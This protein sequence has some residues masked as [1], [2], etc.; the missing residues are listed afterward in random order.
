[1]KKIEWPGIATAVGII[2]ILALIVLGARDDF[3]LKEWQTVI[4]SVIALT[5]G[6]LAYV[7]A[8][9][10]VRAEN[11]SERRELDRKKIGAYYRLGFAITQ[12]LVDSQKVLDRTEYKPFA[13]P[14]TFSAAD[15]Q[16]SKPPEIDELWADIEIFPKKAIADIHCI[17]VMF[18]D[19]DEALKSGPENYQ[20]T[21]LG[22]RNDK[23][24]GKY[25]SALDMLRG[26]C[27]RTAQELNDAI[28]DLEAKG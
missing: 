10:K 24:F 3:H 28:G 2:L 25:I 22:A 8:M 11:D 12:L 4:A 20:A 23:Y 26:A 15:L 21:R 5:G 27:R 9:A 17:R 7:S 1:M 13:A 14:D 6:G 16:L 18:R 19:M